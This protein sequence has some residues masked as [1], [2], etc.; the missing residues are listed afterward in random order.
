MPHGITEFPPAAT[1]SR[2]LGWGSS[3]RFS[4]H[5][6]SLI[7]VVSLSFLTEWWLLSKRDNS[8]KASLSVQALTKLLFVSYH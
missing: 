3:S 5:M 7:S 4:F 6:V 8:K 2:E 1:F